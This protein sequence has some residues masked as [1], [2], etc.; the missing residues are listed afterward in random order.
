MRRFGFVCLLSALAAM[1]MPSVSA[2][3]IISI[4]IAPP[5]LP[6]YLQ[7]VLPA[8]GYIWTPG[9]WAYGPDGYF[10]VPGT[11]VQPPEV[12]LLWTPG[13]WGWQDGVYAYNAGYWG[14]NIGFY[15]GVNYGYGYGGVG[16]EGGRWNNGVFAYN[17]TVN[18]FG[19]VRVTNVYRQTIIVNTNATRA[20]FNGGAGGT[21]AQPT[22]Q[23][24]AAAREQHVAATPMQAQHEHTASTNKALLASVNNGHP[25]IAATSKP[26]EFTGRGVVAAR[27]AK[28]STPLR[29]TAPANVGAIEKRATINGGTPTKP[30]NTEAKP[31]AAVP[32]PKAAAPPKRP[33]TEAK[34]VAAVPPPHAAAPNPPPPHPL[35]A[36]PPH[37]TAAAP[38]PA[39]RPGAPPPKNAEKKPPA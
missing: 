16:Y 31:V 27:E 38:H 33:N 7:P 6:V 4:T 37:P 14:S 23:E 32:P 19:G 2:A 25:A 11:W 24:Q 34:P 17:S 8:P 13:Y 22:A 15:G 10:W 26:G 9:Y 1:A 3:Q 5:E 35:A 20:S 39:A 36:A 18:N 29:G 21:T 30:L 12:G 28:P